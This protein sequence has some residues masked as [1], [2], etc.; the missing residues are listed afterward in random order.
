[1]FSRVPP[2]PIVQRVKDAFLEGKTALTCSITNTS[3]FI[4][5][6]YQHY[7]TAFESERDWLFA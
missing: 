6:P 4:P 2:F 3:H 1:M 7:H 5:S